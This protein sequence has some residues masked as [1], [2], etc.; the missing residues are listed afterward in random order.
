MIRVALQSSFSNWEDKALLPLTKQDMPCMK[1]HPNSCH[2]ESANMLMLD[3]FARQ[4]FSSFCSHIFLLNF[5]F[6]L[7]LLLTPTV[8][9]WQDKED[10][11]QSICTVDNKQREVVELLKLAQ[12][13]SIRTPLKH[14]WSWQDWFFGCQ[15]NFWLWLHTEI[16]SRTCQSL[17][18][19]SRNYNMKIF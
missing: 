4:E 19:Q 12:R 17:D 13:S 15:L 18:K 14:K 9:H 1:L 2:A 10:E 3:Y 11:L 6:W 8:Q 7:T 5:Q 16:P